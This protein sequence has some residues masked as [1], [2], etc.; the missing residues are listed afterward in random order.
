MTTS[1]G[2][3]YMF[4]SAVSTVVPQ[5][6]DVFIK[7]EPDRTLLLV[8][9]GLVLVGFVLFAISFESYDSAIPMGIG[10]I[11]IIA[12]VISTPIAAQI[13]QTDHQKVIT[14]NMI[15]NVR[16]KYHAELQVPKDQTTHLDKFMTYTLTFDNGVE[17][18]YRMKFAQ[19]SE[20]IIASDAAAPS[21]E[22]LNAD[23][24]SPSEAERSANK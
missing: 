4:S 1:L 3:N 6:A 21:P 23:A 18:T 5:Y 19:T 20:P 7:P 8:V 9:V 14:K 10:L 22:E 11:L 17:G 13:R 16:E 15:D 12:G 2:S 24:A